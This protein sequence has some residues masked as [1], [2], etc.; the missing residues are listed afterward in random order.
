M[1]RFYLNYQYLIK[2]ESGL[3]T[4][5]LYISPGQIVADLKAY[6]FIKDTREITDL[7]VFSRGKLVPDDGEKLFEIRLL[8]HL[9]EN[10]I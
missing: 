9:G 10:V 6:M 8:L 3:Y 4:S 5:V 7:D 2:R 1:A